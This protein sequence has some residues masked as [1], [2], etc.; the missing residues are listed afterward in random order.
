MTASQVSLLNFHVFKFLFSYRMLTF[1]WF[2]IQQTGKSKHFGFIEFESPEVAKIVA[3]SM[4]N[5]LLFEHLLQVDL[6]PPERVHPKL[7]NGADRIYEPLNWTQI[8]RKRHNKERTLEEHKKFVERILKRS[9]K[10]KKKI[11]A[12]GIEYECP[13]IVGN[14]Q[15]APKKIKFDDEES[16]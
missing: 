9:Q 7:W 13:E 11:E 4:H 12:A 10:R 16:E 8:E 1:F 15:A 6:V 2:G 3:E 14:I 5:Y